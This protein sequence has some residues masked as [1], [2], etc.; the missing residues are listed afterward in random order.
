[1]RQVHALPRQTRRTKSF[2]RWP[3]AVALLLIIYII[4]AIL[5]PL[6]ALTTSV[7]QPVIPAQVNVALPWPPYGESAFGV[8]GYGLLASHSDQKPV[9]TASV[10]KVLTALAILQKKPLRLGQSGPLLTMT[11]HDVQLYNDYV[12]KDGSVVPIREGEQVSEYQ[13]LQ[14]MLLP[15]ANNIAATAADWAFGSVAAYTTYANDFAKSL[16]MTQ[17]HIADASGFS[18]DTLSTAADLVRL[19][20][21]ALASPV[22]AQIVA[23]PQADF[24]EFGIIHNVNSLLGRAGVIGIKTG[25]TDQ[26]GGVFLV[27]AQVPAG[28]TT[29]TSVAAVMDAPTLAAAMQV[30][31]P[32]V[33]AAHKNLQN[34]AVIQ[35]GQIVGRVTSAWGMSSDVKAQSPLT[36]LAWK[37]TTLTPHINLASVTTPAPAHI[38]AGTVDLTFNSDKLTS[39]LYLD[40]AIRE[41]SLWWRLT[42]PL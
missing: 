25:N 2:A 27:A 34:V 12:A 29:V 35:T 22:I 20:D 40:K 23:Q 11:T 28:N 30:S 17:T 10:A 36:V 33:M 21:A 7:I 37:G 19:G 8:A 42:H 1:M 5:R 15:S 31:V 13:A 39:P 26:A 14:A 3:L 32:L 6:P 41:P 24:P 4:Y 16:G 9:P 18:A 38:P